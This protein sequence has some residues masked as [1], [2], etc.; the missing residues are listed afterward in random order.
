MKLVFYKCDLC[1]SIFELHNIKN[2]KDIKVYSTTLNLLEGHLEGEN[3]SM[4]L[5]SMKIEVCP[6]CM[7]QIKSKV[8]LL[9]GEKRSVN[10]EI[11]RRIYN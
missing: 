3:I 11:K 5:D 7:D 10:K 4:I 6:D 8:K 2:D 9:E 1:N